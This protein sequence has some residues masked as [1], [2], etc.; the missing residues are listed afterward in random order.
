MEF[1]KDLNDEKYGLYCMLGEMVLY[2]RKHQKGII[3]I[4]LKSY[5]MIKMYEKYAHKSKF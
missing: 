1:A 2:A 5:K 3:N 4:I